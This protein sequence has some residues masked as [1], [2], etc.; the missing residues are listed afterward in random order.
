MVQVASV[1]RG[2]FDYA[3]I[4]SPTGPIAYPS[5][6]CLVYGALHWLDFG[7]V[8]AQVSFAIL[9]LGTVAIVFQIYWLAGCPGWLL[10]LCVL[11]K[12][13]H[14][15]YVLRLFNDAVSQFFSYLALLIFL[16]QRHTVFAL[17]YSFAVS[18]KMQPLLHCPAV[19]LCLVL[20]RGWA[21]TLRSIAIM[22]ALQL[23]LALP[24]LSTNPAAYLARAFGGPGHLQ[25]VWSVNW[26]LL[27]GYMFES[28]A[29][30]AGLFISNLALWA[31]FA[32][33]RW[34]PN[35][36]FNQKVWRWSG[37]AALNNQAV[38]C[39]WFACNL[40]GIVCLR[41]LHFQFLC[42]YFHTIPFLA[43]Y[44]LQPEQHRG[45]PWALRCV[46]VAALTAAVE[47]PFLLTTN[48]IVRGPDG[49]TWET[50]GV[51]TR[52][53][54]VLLLVAHGLLLGLL[55]RCEVHVVDDKRS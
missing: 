45:R 53:G 46:A 14:S 16:Y 13:V 32:H 49:R 33:K 10:T 41:T 24:F 7:I 54:S 17:I 40:V 6:F 34:I 27:P 37:Q 44:A 8:A 35:G 3:E 51:P 12:R 48:G 25:H 2:Q 42:W 31:W 38:V 39:I 9:Y 18:V 55:A 22:L 19:G 29:F 21:F 28:R 1:L 43:W 52:K 20:R 5:G 15:I 36:A 50:Q 30:A 47:V 26:K 11:S 23:G 4:Q